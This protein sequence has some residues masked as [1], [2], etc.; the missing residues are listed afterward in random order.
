[1][2]FQLKELKTNGEAREV[3]RKLNGFFQRVFLL[4]K[5]LG[6]NFPLSSIVLPIVNEELNNLNTFWEVLQIILFINSAQIV[7]Y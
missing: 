7:F 2:R 6:E 3:F 4:N 1:L 5:H